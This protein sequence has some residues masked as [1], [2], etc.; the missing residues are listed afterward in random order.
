MGLTPVCLKKI[1]LSTKTIDVKDDVRDLR[2][3]VD[4]LLAHGLSLASQINVF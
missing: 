1:L 3:N 4:I 2:V